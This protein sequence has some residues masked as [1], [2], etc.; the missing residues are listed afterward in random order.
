MSTTTSS[1]TPGIIELVGD[2]A[3]SLIQQCLEEMTA[4]DWSALIK[5]QVGFFV[6][7]VSVPTTPHLRLHL[8]LACAVVIMSMIVKVFEHVVLKL[9]TYS[10]L[11]VTMLF[12][13]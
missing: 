1:L 2:G 4:D 13:N 12:L 6:L 10:T 3:A 7:Y 5:H 8:T 11:Y 9:L